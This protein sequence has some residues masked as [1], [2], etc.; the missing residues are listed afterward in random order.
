[1][2]LVIQIQ[3]TAIVVLVV[4]FLVARFTKEDFLEKDHGFLDIIFWSLVTIII[5]TAMLRIWG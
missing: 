1:M 4:I 5:G 3:Q 2:E